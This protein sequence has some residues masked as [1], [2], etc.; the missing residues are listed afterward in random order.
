MGG[1]VPLVLCKTEIRTKPK[2]AASHTITSATSLPWQPEP[3]CVCC[4]SN[5]HCLYPPPS[6]MSE[7]QKLEE[8]KFT[9][10]PRPISS[11]IWYLFIYTHL[12]TP[13][14][15]IYMWTHMECT[16]TLSDLDKSM[17][18][19]T[20]VLCWPLSLSF[21][22]SI[23]S[24]SSSFSTLSVFSHFYLPLHCL[25]TCPLSVHLSDPV[26]MAARRQIAAI[27]HQPRYRPLIC[28]AG[29]N[30]VHSADTAG[31]IKE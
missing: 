27:T 24:S 7:R 23:S 2:T 18:R 8:G 19:S 20:F 4:D 3:R 6:L 10:M 12:V 1:L 16:V 15:S 28:L 30:S 25:S 26:R 14:L 29:P 17:K 21:V 13:A 9:D 31:N 22:H 11:W 5:Q